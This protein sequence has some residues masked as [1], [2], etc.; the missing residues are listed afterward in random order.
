MDWKGLRNNCFRVDIGETEDAKL[1]EEFIELWLRFAEEVVPANREIRWD[2]LYIS[3]KGPDG[4]FEI[5]PQSQDAFPHASFWVA[6]S[7]PSFASF[8]E[9]LDEDAPREVSKRED[10]RIAKIMVDAAESIHFAQLAGFGEKGLL[11]R[12]HVYEGEEPFYKAVI[13]PDKQTVNC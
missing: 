13:G 8:Y 12:F 10:L 4:Y 5:W 6:L 7:M 11:T 3:V 9:Q 1:A 2:F